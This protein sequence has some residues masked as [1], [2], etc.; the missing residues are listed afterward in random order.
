[1]QAIILAAGMGKRLKKLTKNNTKCMVEVNGVSLIDRL[2]G[3]I[4]RHNFSR[5]VIVTGYKGKE[6]VEHIN[7][8]S[9]KTPIVFIDNLVYDKTNN[10]YS[11]SL[12]T[13]YLAKED[14]VLFESDLIFEDRILDDLIDDSRET[15]ALVDKYESW[16]DGTCLK[17]DEEDNPAACGILPL[18]KISIPRSVSLFS[19]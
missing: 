19:N 15:L 2:L 1:M 9:V 12:A 18:T 5:V 16:M 17:L 3:Q 14:T 4:D 13:E 11:L 8:I 6:L 7:G 10:I